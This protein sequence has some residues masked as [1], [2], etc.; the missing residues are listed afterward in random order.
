MFVIKV[1]IIYSHLCVTIILSQYENSVTCF[2]RDNGTQTITFDWNMNTNI[3]NITMRMTNMKRIQITQPV[4]CVD[5]SQN[6]LS[7]WPKLEYPAYVTFL[8][9]SFNSL[10][11]WNSDMYV[12]LEALDLSSNLLARIDLSALLRM[13][14]LKYLFLANNLIT[15]FG[16]LRQTNLHTLVLS[17]ERWYAINNIDFGK[18]PI[19]AVFDTNPEVEKLKQ[20]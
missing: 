13:P 16:G 3:T 20:V 15:Y 19:N 6:E 17:A 4:R 11:V 5:L 2:Q 7:T 14:K 18:N 1:L 8:N 9:L 12:N 10:Q